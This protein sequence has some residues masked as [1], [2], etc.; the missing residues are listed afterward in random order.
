M[1]LTPPQALGEV[2]LGVLTSLSSLVSVSDPLYLPLSL[3][4]LQHHKLPPSPRPERPS[5]DV[6]LAVTGRERSSSCS[7]WLEVGSGRRMCG[8]GCGLCVFS[9][10]SGVVTDDW[11]LWVG[12]WHLNLSAYLKNKV[13]MPS[14]PLDSR[15]A[16]GRCERQNMG[17]GASVAVRV[18]DR[19]PRRRP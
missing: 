2:S 11:S 1:P 6:A 19:Y 16:A 9:V 4:L 3:R 10:R 7:P 8:P 15:L 14:L 5:Q 18:T 17:L 12:P 13:E